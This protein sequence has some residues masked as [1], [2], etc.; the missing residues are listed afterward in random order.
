VAGAEH[1]IEIDVPPDAMYRVITDYERYPE[2]LPEMETVR[3]VRRDGET[4]DVHFTLNLVKRLTYTLRLVGRP[5]KGLDWSLVEGGFKANNGGWTLEAL[6]GG[7]TR[8]SYRVHVEVGVFV[9]GAIA[10]RLI[11]QTLPATLKNFKARA[12]SL[13]RNGTP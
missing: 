8:A 11:G 4:C 10:N 7:R 9:P 12:E 1:S 3:V 2:F 5:G 6:P 13:A